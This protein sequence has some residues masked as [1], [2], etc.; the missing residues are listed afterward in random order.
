MH[1]SRN[2]ESGVRGERRGEDVRVMLGRVGRRLSRCVA[3]FIGERGAGR[4][5]D[6]VN[7]G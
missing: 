4:E 1:L 2:L 3:R 6:G 5:G 7:I